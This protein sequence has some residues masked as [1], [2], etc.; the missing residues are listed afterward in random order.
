MKIVRYIVDITFD[1]EDDLSASQLCRILGKSPVL[2]GAFI[3]IDKEVVEE[4]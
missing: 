2:L 1:N 4:K 3:M